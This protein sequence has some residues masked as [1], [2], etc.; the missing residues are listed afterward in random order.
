MDLRNDLFYS[1]DARP[2]PEEQEVWEV[3]NTVLEN[4]SKVLDE[5]KNYRGASDEIRQVNTFVSVSLEFIYKKNNGIVYLLQ[6]GGSGST[7]CLWLGVFSR[8]SLSCAVY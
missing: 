7:H 2:T 5:L 6:G 3:V 8:L 4:S 1:S